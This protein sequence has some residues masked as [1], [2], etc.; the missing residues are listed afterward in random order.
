MKIVLG[1]TLVAEVRATV[2]V[3]GPLA[4]ANLAQTAMGFTN[5]V[6]VGSLGSA[7]LAAAGLGTSLYFT[8][9]MACS[10]VLTAVAPLAAHAIG[11][12]DNRRAGQIARHG[13]VL[14]ALL[15]TP[16]IVAL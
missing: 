13:L 5:T 14:A 6:M 10:G 3:A 11:A 15:A 12:R 7:A 1:P 8:I 2:A 4:A 16:V 9:T